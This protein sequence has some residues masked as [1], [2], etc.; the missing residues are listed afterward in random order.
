MLSWMDILGYDGCLHED[1]DRAGIEQIT[2]FSFD[3]HRACGSVTANP[4]SDEEFNLKG[5]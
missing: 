4:F 5:Y 1:V 2:L 3:H